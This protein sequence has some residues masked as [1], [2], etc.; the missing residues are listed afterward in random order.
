M[1]LWLK[2][3]HFLPGTKEEEEKRGIGKVTVCDVLEETKRSDSM[4]IIPIYDWTLFC[5][6]RVAVIDTSLLELQTVFIYP[7]TILQS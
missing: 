4:E 7:V 2:L 3:G 1:C 6:Y 5:A